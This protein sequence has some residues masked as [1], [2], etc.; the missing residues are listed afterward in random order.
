MNPRISQGDSLPFIESN[1]G[2]KLCYEE[3][4]GALIRIS[5]ITSPIYRSSVPQT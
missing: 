4:A 2:A 3:T 1:E 5:P